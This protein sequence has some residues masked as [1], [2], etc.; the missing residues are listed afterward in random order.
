MCWITGRL[1]CKVI[2]YSIVGVSLLVARASEPIPSSLDAIR[3][4]IEHPDAQTINNWLKYTCED[5]FQRGFETSVL[6]PQSAK[7]K[8]ALVEAFNDDCETM[9]L[10]LFKSTDGIKWTY[11][12]TVQLELAFGT[13]PPIRLVAF[14]G[15]GIKDVLV[16]HEIVDWGSGILQEDISVYRIFDGHLK[17]VLEEPET[18]NYGPRPGQRSVEQHSNFEIRE[19]EP[20]NA[21]G[22]KYLHEDQQI[23]IG[24]QTLR[25]FRSCYWDDRKQ[26]FQFEEDSK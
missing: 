15:K 3:H 19:L 11:S 13:R 1:L 16:Q 8:Y 7:G 17:C 12:D 25:R 4:A 20:G 24:K 22:G 9:P 6:F 5:G 18:V 14:A 21:T 2:S 26:R 10:V 23:T